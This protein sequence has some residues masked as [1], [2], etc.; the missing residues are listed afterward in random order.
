MNTQDEATP[1][2]G[3]HARN[4]SL[5]ALEIRDLRTNNLY[6]IPIRHNAVPAVEFAA[7]KAPKNTECVVV[8]QD[9]TGLRVF[10]PGFQNTAVVESNVTYVYV[11]CL[12]A[13]TEDCQF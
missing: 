6:T 2:N 9:Q 10:D 1:A 7:I 13:I 8:D 11:T 12:N 4:G 3:K 5:Q